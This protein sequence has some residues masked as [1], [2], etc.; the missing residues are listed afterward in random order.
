MAEPKGGLAFIPETSPESIQANK[1]YQEA[2]N[3][4]N[5][6]LEARQNKMF[7]PTMLALAEGFLTPG[8]TG[9]FGE[10]L[11]TAAGKM[12]A[13]EEVESKQEQELAQAKL[14]LAQQ[15]MQLARQKQMSDVAKAHFFGQGVS[16]PSGGAVGATPSGAEIA[17]GAS[18]A[19]RGV[20]DPAA[21]YIALAY[22]RGEDPDK[23]EQT[24]IKI[25]ID[26]NKVVEG[27]VFNT[28]TGKFDPFGIKEAK[29]TVDGQSYS[30]PVSVSQQY[31]DLIK[32]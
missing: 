10:A 2:L 6:A 23:I 4:L 8:R 20:T 11:G 18:G 12:R 17:T 30:V 7:D 32:Q 28:L 29:V 5:S 3:R 13:A 31:N 22:A 16:R 1:A 15:Q 14:G 21:A 25:R 9:S 24:A 19:P 26:A 27:G